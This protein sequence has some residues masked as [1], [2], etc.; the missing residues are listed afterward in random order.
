MVIV[1]V[2]EVSPATVCL[3]T[4]PLNE[5]FDDALARPIAGWCLAPG[6]VE[7]DD[8]VDRIVRDHETTRPQTLSLFNAPADLAAR[9][10]RM[11][12]A[13]AEEVTAAQSDEVDALVRLI[14]QP[15]DVPVYGTSLAQLLDA[16]G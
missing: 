14:D 11:G 12:A 6:G 16:S 15:A 3:P 2:D 10:Q 4:R 13:R 1:R 5:L 9:Y 7:I 8:V